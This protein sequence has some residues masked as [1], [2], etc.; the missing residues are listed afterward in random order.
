MNPHPNAASNPPVP[1]L[2]H[3]ESLLAEVY[4]WMQGGWEAKVSQ[5]RELFAELGLTPSKP[6]A[7]AVDLG[8][9]TGYQ[10]APLASLGFAVTAIDA[11]ASMLSQ[12]RDHVSAT[13][14]VAAVQ[15]VEA[16]I[17]RFTD[18]VTAPVEL[19]VCMGDTLA[20]LPSHREVAEV[21]AAA[22]GVQ[23]PGGRI[24]L[25]FRDGSQAL[26]GDSRFIPVRSSDERVFTCFIEELD[27]DTVRVHDVLHVKSGDGFEQNVSSYNKIRLST[28]WMAEQLTEAGYQPPATSV[29][30]GMTIMSAV[31]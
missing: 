30:A 4:D 18:H 3:Y 8:A 10:T 11:S 20:H 7:S 6:G 12:L 24:V 5:S 2:E 19:V 28:Q 15:T 29:V 16:D 22:F 25:G 21:L 27:D 26:G 1:S 13:P 17:C 31:R 14:A 9:G 23:E